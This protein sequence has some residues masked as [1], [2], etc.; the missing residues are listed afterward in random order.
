MCKRRTYAPLTG[1][2]EGEPLELG[3]LVQA[4]AGQFVVLVVLVDQIHQD[5]ETLPAFRSV[6]D[7]W[8]HRQRTPT[9]R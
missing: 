3:V 2:L 7:T 1:G 5:G 9:K 8:R 4:G 6:I